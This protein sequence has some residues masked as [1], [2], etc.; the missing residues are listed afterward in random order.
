MV[1]DVYRIYLVN[2]I[3]KLEHVGKYISGSAENAALDYAQWS[4]EDGSEYHIAKG[5]HI[6]VEVSNSGQKTRFNIS[7]EFMASYSA[8]E[9]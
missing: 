1:Y 8:E 9:V 4:D 3:E 5:N 7:G 2:D 6:L